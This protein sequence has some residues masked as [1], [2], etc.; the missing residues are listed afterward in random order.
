MASEAHEK[1]RAGM[2][3]KLPEKTGKTLEQWVRVAKRAPAAARAS[4]AERE[5][6]RTELRS[7]IDALTAECSDQSNRGNGLANASIRACDEDS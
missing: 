5:I 7:R 6:L 2:I 3:A 4:E 1:K